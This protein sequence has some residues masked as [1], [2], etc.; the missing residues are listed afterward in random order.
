MKSKVC[1]GRRIFSE[2]RWLGGPDR[3]AGKHHS[4][5]VFSFYDPDGEGFELMKHSPPHL[6]GRETTVCAFENRPTLLQCARCLHLGHTSPNCK[7]SKTFIACTKCGGPHQTAIH[8]YHCNIRGAK[9]KGTHCDCPPSCFLCIEKKLSGKDHI[10]TDET[11][12]LWKHFQTSL[13]AAIDEAVSPSVTSAPK[14]STPSAWSPTPPPPTA[15]IDDPNVMADI[16]PSP[17]AD[18]PFTLVPKPDQ[19]INRIT[20]LHKEGKS[21]SEIG[22]IFYNKE[23]AHA[24]GSS[25]NV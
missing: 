11:C 14:P 21:L 24:A 6:F 18:G 16:T 8:K 19:S 9:H 7:R 12:P 17:A 20:A 23:L 4:S 5:I 22:Q 10:S 25:I 2:P 1:A 15:R 13:R 3:L